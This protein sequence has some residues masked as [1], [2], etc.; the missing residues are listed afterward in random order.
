MARK[1]FR[2]EYKVPSATARLTFGNIVAVHFAWHFP[3][4]LLAT[5]SKR[6]DL[7]ISIACVS[8]GFVAIFQLSFGVVSYAAAVSSGSQTRR[9]CNNER[10][11]LMKL[12]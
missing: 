10:D 5:D 8:D 2:L 11:T 7:S 9:A 3:T 12:K 4:I 1:S 6:L